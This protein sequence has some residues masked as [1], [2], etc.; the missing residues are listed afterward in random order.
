M[1]HNLCPLKQVGAHIAVGLRHR[2]P[3]NQRPGGKNSQKQSSRQVR[4]FHTVKSGRLLITH[5]KASF[6]F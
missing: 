4:F 6:L 2:P 1:R 3:G 5:V